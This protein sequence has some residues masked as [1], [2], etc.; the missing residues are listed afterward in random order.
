MQKTLQQLET[1]LI[2]LQVI[3]KKMGKPEVKTSGFF[4]R[5]PRNVDSI[6]M[7]RKKKNR[8]SINYR[9]MSCNVL[10]TR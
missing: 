7:L 2:I 9:Q 3:N 8:L 5:S 1:R 4:G 10:E 6:G